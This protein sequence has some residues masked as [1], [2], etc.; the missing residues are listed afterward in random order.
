MPMQLTYQ[1]R[2][3]LNE[4]L[5]IQELQW[6]R[7]MPKLLPL[8]YRIHQILPITEETNLCFSNDLSIKKLNDQFRGKN[9]PTNVLTFELPGGGMIG[10]DIIFA[11]QTIQKE[12]QQNKRPFMHHLAHLIIHGLLH[13]QGYDHIYVNEAKEME[14][15]EAL[16]L[17]KLNIPNPWKLYPSR[18]I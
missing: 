18:S 4:K 12:A 6:R 13:L 11:L 16:L 1:T 10:G 15:R 14:M 5:I 9:K 17:Q 2:Q 8:L 7:F 3:Q